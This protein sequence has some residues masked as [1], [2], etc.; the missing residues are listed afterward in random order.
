MLVE[1]SATLVLVVCVRQVIIPPPY[2][3]E[4][5]QLVPAG[6]PRA[7]E[8][9]K[10]VVSVQSSCAADLKPWMS[11]KLPLSTAVPERG[12]PRSDIV[13]CRVYS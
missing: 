5:C 3:L 10:L 13:C 6:D 8:R 7:L 4:E 11:L 12:E 2:G 9:V 1:A